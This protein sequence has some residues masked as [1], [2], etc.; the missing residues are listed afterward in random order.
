MFYC[1]TKLADPTAITGVSDNYSLKK[2]FFK[3]DLS[4]QGMLFGYVTHQPVLSCIVVILL[5]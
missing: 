3:I 4:I 1:V 2:V 5:W